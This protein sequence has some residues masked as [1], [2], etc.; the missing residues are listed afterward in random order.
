[1]C[2]RDSLGDFDDRGV[3][4]KG[5]RVGDVIVG[6]AAVLEPVS[7][8]HLF[9][10]NCYQ[11]NVTVT[12]GRYNTLTEDTST[13]KTTEEFANGTVA[14]LLG[15]AFTNGNGFPVLGSSPADYTA[16]DAAPVSYTHLDV[17]KSKV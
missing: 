3:N 9:T 8:T 12:P 13:E 1:M 14:N 7:Y 2:I 5:Q 16:V 15:E 4:I 11:G 10:T 6:N 17:Y